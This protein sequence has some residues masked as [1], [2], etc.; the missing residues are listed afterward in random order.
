MR[1]A[2]LGIIIL[3]A[4]PS[5]AAWGQTGK[6]LAIGAGMN[7][8]RFADNTFSS[9]NPG[10]SFEYRIHRHSTQEDGWKWSPKTSVNL[11]K[12]DTEMNVGGASTKAGRLQAA[13]VMIGVERGY[14]QGPF[15]IGASVIAGPSFN[16][17]DVDGAARTAYANTGNTLNGISAKNSIAVKPGISAWYDLGSW[18]ALHGSAGY[19]INRP[20]VETTVNGVTTSSTWKTDHTSLEMGL[21]VG[22]F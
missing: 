7:Y 16:Q 13:R 11:S 15:K 18:F 4:V 19:V 8:H 9:S 14:R 5:A 20:T 21:V 6:R 3:I 10:I 17:F 2:L 1:R 22:I 12:M